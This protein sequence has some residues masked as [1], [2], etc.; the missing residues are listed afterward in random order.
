MNRGDVRS[1]FMKL[2]N[3]CLSASIATCT[4]YVQLNAVTARRSEVPSCNSRLR[5]FTV[6]IQSGSR[7]SMQTVL[8][9]RP[10][11]YSVSLLCPSRRAEYCDQSVC[12]SVCLSVFVCLSTNISLKP[13]DRSACTSLFV[14]IPY[15]PQTIITCLL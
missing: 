7:S 13:L 8:K 6:V 3:H 12:P 1:V 5:L 11:S 10:N 15:L 14:R 4:K 9:L 2:I